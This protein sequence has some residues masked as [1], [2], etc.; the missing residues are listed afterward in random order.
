MLEYPI[1][2][3]QLLNTYA[4]YELLQISLCLNVQLPNTAHN[5]IALFLLILLQLLISTDRCLFLTLTF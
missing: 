5:G 1:I 4:N 3:R 2:F